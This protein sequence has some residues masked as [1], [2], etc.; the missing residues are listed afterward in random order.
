LWRPANVRAKSPAA[1]N[2]ATS[3]TSASPKKAVAGCATDYMILYLAG[4]FW[5]EESDIEVVFGRDN[6]NKQL[7]IRVPKKLPA[8]VVR[9]EGQC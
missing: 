1:P 3:S 2:S 6:V 7:R 4:C 9:T 5:V 8:A